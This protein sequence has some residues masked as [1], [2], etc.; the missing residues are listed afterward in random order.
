MQFMLYF[1][2]TNDH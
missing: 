2:R 1:V